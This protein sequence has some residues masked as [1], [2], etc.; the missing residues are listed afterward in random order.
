VS[1][2]RRSTTLLHT[3]QVFD[4]CPYGTLV[5]HLRPTPSNKSHMTLDLV[6]SP[7]DKPRKI[8]HRVCPWPTVSIF[9]LP[10]TTP[11]GPSWRFSLFRVHL[12]FTL[13][14]GAAAGRRSSRRCTRPGRWCVLA[15]RTRCGSSHSSL[16]TMSWARYSGTSRK[17]R[18]GPLAAHRA[19]LPSPPL[20]ESHVGSSRLRGVFPWQWQRDPG[21]GF[22]GC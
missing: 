22:R 9:C 1:N 18:R 2:G 7:H 11:P 17:Q 5:G 19:Q 14:D 6:R 16:T 21:S 15:P 3:Q 4:Y 20:P 8:T 13:S 12:G 10:G